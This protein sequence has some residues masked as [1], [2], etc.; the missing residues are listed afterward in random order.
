MEGGRNSGSPTNYPPESNASLLGRSAK[1]LRPAA[2]C[3]S[4]GDCFILAIAHA[5]YG[6][7]FWGPHDK[8]QPISAVFQ[9]VSPR[10][11]PLAYS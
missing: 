5:I 8:G 10:I 4:E 7:T 6:Q 11:S 1:L 9:V 3:G 2:T